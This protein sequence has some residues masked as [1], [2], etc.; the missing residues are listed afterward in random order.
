MNAYATRRRPFVG[1]APV[2]PLYPDTI[3]EDITA[4]AAAGTPM[5]TLTAQM[6]Q[7]G[8]T[9]A[10]ISQLYNNVKSTATTTPQ[11]FDYL[12][13][14]NSYLQQQYL[15]NSRVWMWVLLGGGALLLLS[16][17]RR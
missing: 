10:Q 9:A 3:V 17:R 6:L 15:D 11:I 8:Y 5:G 4:A 12:Q 14:E 1:T 13:R 7:L 2:L 16:D